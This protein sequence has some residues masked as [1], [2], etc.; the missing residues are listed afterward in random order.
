M[1]V[2][3]YLYKT[4]A[5][6]GL[7][8]IA[9]FVLNIVIARIYG[10]SISGNFF[11][12]LS[13]YSLIIL[14][15]SFSL[16][17][18]LGFYAS[19]DPYPLNRLFSLSII[20]VSIV[21]VL[22]A[23]IFYIFPQRFIDK[24]QLLYTALPFIAGNILMT[25]MASM[26]YAKKHFVLP[27]VIM[28][29]IYGC[30]FLFIPGFIFNIVTASQ[31]LQLYQWSF[32]IIAFIMGLFFYITEISSYKWEWPSLE[33]IKPIVRFSA[34]AWVGNIV[35]F[36]LYRIDYWFVEYYC[37]PVHLGNY[38][39]VSRLAQVFFLIPS[40]IASVIFPVTASAPGREILKQIA[41]ISRLF[42][43]LYIMICLVLAI[44]GYWLFAWLFGESYNQMYIPFLLLIPGII[45]LSML[46]PITAYNAGM[47]K[48]KFNL[49]A[50]FVAL[51]CMIVGDLFFIPLYG[52][53]AAAAVSS[54][55]YLVLHFVLFFHLKKT[56]KIHVTTFFI[57]QK[58]DFSILK[59]YFTGSIKN[60][61]GI[62]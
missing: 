36:F 49:K 16:E 15:V 58:N 4:V 57:L 23:W 30:L 31:Y 35:F 28:L 26:F 27:N 59:S 42:F 21:S 3:N 55:S 38:I 44:S 51:A 37:S 14:V 45:S 39:Q 8:Y 47:S 33:T 10:A 17:S 60:Q 46:Y 12:N 48:L 7:V 43:W 54:V 50:C 22:L 13:I 34:W 29:A 11:Y 1:N 25:F 2:S 20:W 52:M 19:A 32:L 53:Y 5:W 18:G 40:I 41:I 6:R 61:D 24:N 62:H 9:A 56:Q